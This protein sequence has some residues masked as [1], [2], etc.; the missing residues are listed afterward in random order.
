MFTNIFSRFGSIFRCINNT[1]FSF[2]L[3]YFEAVNLLR[4]DASQKTGLRR[5]RILA[6][7]LK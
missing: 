5:L 3:F 2:K 7:F 4:S 6:A 1:Y